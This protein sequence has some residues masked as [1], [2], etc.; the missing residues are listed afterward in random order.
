MKGKKE[1]E[2]FFRGIFRRVSGCDCRLRPR[3]EGGIVVEVKK[4]SRLS[5]ES[6][7]EG[8][9]NCSPTRVRGIRS[10]LVL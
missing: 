9:L 1:D 6:S 3:S 4:V 10:V 2:G 5:C 7:L 8:E